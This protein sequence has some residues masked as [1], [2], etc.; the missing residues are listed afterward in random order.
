ML[1][2]FWIGLAKAG[3]NP[4]DA[5]LVVSS[6]ISLVLVFIGRFRTR[7]RG[8]RGEQRAHALTSAESSASPLRRGLESVEGLLGRQLKG[9]RPRRI[10]GAEWRK[11]RLSRFIVPERFE[12]EWR[13][14]FLGC[15]GWGCAFLGERSDTRV[16][17][18]VPRGFEQLFLNHGVSSTTIDDRLLRRITERAAVIERLRHPHL[19]RLLGYSGSAPILIYEYADYGTLWDQLAQKWRPSVKEVVLLGVQLGDAIRYIHS[20]G[21]V[22]GDLKPS[23]IFI[24][25]G[26]ARIGDF[27]GLTTLLAST[28]KIPSQATP[29]WRAPEQV[30]A[31][32]NLAAR[33]R[34]VENRVDIYQLGNLLLYLLTGDALD[35]AE[36]LDKDKLNSLLNKIEDIDLRKLLGSMLATEPWKRPSSDEVVKSLVALYFK[37]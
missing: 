1:E 2:R 22:H 13:I 32:L 9:L 34:G 4:S 7:G 11:V 27:S 18:K 31:D 23:N 30:Y 36:A 12:G 5:V 35:G 28:G 10:V 8:A 26:I 16:V 19:L 6:G 21:L 24:V 17:F 25:N 20:R 15:G 33:K 29:G 3:I 14:V 37:I